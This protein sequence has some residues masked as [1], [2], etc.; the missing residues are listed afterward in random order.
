MRE[1]DECGT[2]SACC[3]SICTLLRQQKLIGC[4]YRA[5]CIYV[6]RVYTKVSIQRFSQYLYSFAFSQYLYSFAFSQYWYSFAPIERFSQC[7]YS[8]APATAF[9]V[10]FSHVCTSTARKFR[11]ETLEARGGE[12]WC[13]AG[14]WALTKPPRQKTLSAATSACPACKLYL[15]YW[16]KSTNTDT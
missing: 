13:A 4:L 11:T 7:L 12:G 6:S 1:R 9:C 16:Y 8:F 2:T 14:E 15:L 3:V 10:S 5:V